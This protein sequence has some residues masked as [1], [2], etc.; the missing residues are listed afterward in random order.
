MVRKGLINLQLGTHSVSPFSFFVIGLSFAALFLCGGGSDKRSSPIS[1][2]RH[3]VPVLF[4]DAICFSTLHSEK[5]ISVTC[6]RATLSNPHLTDYPVKWTG[7]LWHVIAWCQGAEADEKRKPS[8]VTHSSH[9]YFP[10]FVWNV[11]SVSFSPFPSVPLLLSILLLKR[12]RTL[13]I[14][15]WR[16]RYVWPSC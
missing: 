12:K 3:L 6:A 14:D 11:M 1:F 5:T 9:S 4:G 15:I 16:H 13:Y 2:S 8:Y 10:I 7:A